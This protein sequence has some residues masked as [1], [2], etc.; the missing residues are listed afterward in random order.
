MEPAAEPDTTTLPPAPLWEQQARQWAQVK[1]PLRPSAADLAWAQQA[2]DR[3]AVGREPAPA[4]LVLGVTPELAALR[5][6]AAGLVLGADLSM[7]MIR[8]LWPGTNGDGVRRV[9][10]QADWLAL[11]LARHSC[12]LVLG[13]GCY[14]TLRRA[15]A[16]PLTQSVH[17]VLKAGG[18]FLIRVYVRPD[19]DVAPAAVWEQLLAHRFGSFHIFKFRLLMSLH[20][21]AGEVRVADAWEYFASRCAQ[22]AHLA[23]RLGWPLDEVRTIGAY[24]GQAAVYWF[25]T[26]AEFRARVAAWFEEIACL[27]PDYEMGEL[28]PTFVLKARG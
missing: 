26:V 10:V 23:G 22:P 18:T 3:C 16:S 20:D 24:R 11:P 7:P 1:P 5:W 25:P 9:A 6:P 17:R 12:D 8:G 28:C 21:G 4:A 19:V 14:V 2:I 15:L 13:D 27:W